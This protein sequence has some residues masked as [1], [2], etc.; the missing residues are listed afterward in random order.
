MIEP[1]NA[2]PP[3]T[4]PVCGFTENLREDKGVSTKDPMGT[5]EPIP[6]WAELAQLQTHTVCKDAGVPAVKEELEQ[7]HHEYWVL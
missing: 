2:P 6:L 7:P 5:D 4:E 1:R 3:Y